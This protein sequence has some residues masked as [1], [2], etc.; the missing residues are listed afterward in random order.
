MQQAARDWQRAA[1]P[2]AN[3]EKAARRL[4]LDFLGHNLG[5]WK[6]ESNH[7]TLYDSLAEICVAIF[8]ETL[9]PAGTTPSF[10]WLD[11]HGA[12]M[13]TCCL[14]DGEVIELQVDGTFLTDGGQASQ[15]VSTQ[16][17]H[18]TFPTGWLK[19]IGEEA[20]QVCGV[21]YVSGEF[22]ATLSVERDR[23]VLRVVNA[24]VLFYG[25]ALGAC[26]WHEAK[27]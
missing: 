3:R 17:A 9:A 24:M 1:S 19:Q 13:T 11:S 4:A 23:E 15:A 18:Q 8:L 22:R 6:N 10:F 14:L 7:W 25:M 27:E 12:I 21:S 5:L 2:R 16:I 20:A 26:R